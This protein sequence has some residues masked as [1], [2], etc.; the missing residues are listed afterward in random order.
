MQLHSMSAIL[1][2]QLDTKGVKVADE[3][4]YI[5]HEKTS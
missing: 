2:E 5:S 3:I 1:T 4:L